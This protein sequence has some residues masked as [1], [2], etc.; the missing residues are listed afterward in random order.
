[1]TSAAEPDA[2]DRPFSEDLEQWLASPGD[3]TLGELTTVFAEKSFAI[4]LMLL[5]FTSAL[6]VPTGGITTIFELI[7][8]VLALQLTVGRPTFWLPKRL[9]HRFLGPAT[10]EK[11]IPFIVRRIRWFER[12]AR[13]RF[14][15]VLQQ[16]ATLSGLGVLMLVGI[17]G[18]FVA[19]PFSGLDTLPAMG[20]VA[21]ALSL[22]LEDA[23][24]TIIGIAIG[25]VGIALEI[26]FGSV[27]L[28]FFS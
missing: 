4:A 1:M 5:M 24:V 8:I 25:A 2:Q 28:S 17:L 9:L 19:P 10:T 12:F 15:S 13:P 27:V 20:V 22:I 18:S 7:A 11:A 21:I 23:V 14:A 16:R 3:N 26:A 6:P